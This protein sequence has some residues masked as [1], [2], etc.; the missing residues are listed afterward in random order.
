MKIPFL[1]VLVDSVPSQDLTPSLHLLLCQPL[2]L[3][4]ILGCT[5]MLLSISQEFF[6][7]VQSQPC[8]PTIS[9][10]VSFQMYSC[11][12]LAPKMGRGSKREGGCMDHKFRRPT[13]PW[14]V[15]DGCILLLSELSSVPSLSAAVGTIL[16]SVAETTRNQS[17]TQHIHLL[18]T[19]CKQLPIIAKNIG[20]RY[21][22][23][24]L[25][26]F[27]DPIF[28]ALSCDNALTSSAA[29]LCLIEI[30]KY[31]GPNILKGRVEQHN[32]DYINKLLANHCAAPL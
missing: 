26:A 6:T 11:G 13:E 7:L 25:E 21:F 23:P 27:L 29:S 32:P 16:P 30:G 20:K 22:K 17:Y 14:E 2:L 24:S 9:T 12:S 31:L 3:F 15:C 1:A 19:I 5:P 8:N 4:P 10:F 28:Y 18:E